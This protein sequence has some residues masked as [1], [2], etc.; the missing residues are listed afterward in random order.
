MYHKKLNQINKTSSHSSPLLDGHLFGGHAVRQLISRLCG[1]QQ[2]P[3]M[4]TVP[5][6]ILDVVQG[7]GLGLDQCLGERLRFGWCLWRHLGFGVKLRSS[8][9]GIW[10]RERLDESLR[11]ELGLRGLGE[12]LWIGWWGLGVR[13][14]LD[15]GWR[16]ECVV[17]LLWDRFGKS[18]KRLEDGLMLLLTA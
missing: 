18:L 17:R 2:F 9:L 1:G 6:E 12:S 3:R 7:Q 16:I 15:V 11:F 10:L 4:D 8:L 13:L 14:G 5:A